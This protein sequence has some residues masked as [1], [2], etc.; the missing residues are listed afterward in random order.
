METAERKELKLSKTDEFQVPPD[1]VVIVEGRNLRSSINIKWVKE[2]KELIRENQQLEAV[3]CNR[4]KDGKFEVRE[5]HHRVMAIKELYAEGLDIKIRVKLE[6]KGTSEEQAIIN[7]IVGSKKLP[8]SGMAIAEG[9]YRLIKCQWTVEEIANK[10]KVSTT[11]VNN[12]N[13]LNAQ[14]RALKAL[15]EL[16]RITPTLAF[17]FIAEGEAAVSKFIEDVNAGLY[18]QKNASQPELVIEQG[19]SATPPPTPSKITKKDV[20]RVNNT[21]NSLKSFQ[22]WAKAPTTFSDR[23]PQEK[24]PVYDFMIKLL[25]NE[26]TELEIIKYFNSE[27]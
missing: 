2:L 18:D 14:P 27:P 10:L 21:V 23:I 1:D 13:A 15:I 7:Q 16:G 17:D 26:L 5:G 22:K 6:A 24:K 8:F 3:I 25:N 20:N 4:G 11:Y 9:I 12:Y 19:Q